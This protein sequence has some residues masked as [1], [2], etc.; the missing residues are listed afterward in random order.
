[1]WKYIIIL[2]Y[3]LLVFLWKFLQTG[4]LSTYLTLQF[5]SFGSL[6]ERFALVFQ[7]APISKIPLKRKNSPIKMSSETKLKKKKIK[8]N[9]KMQFYIVGCP[10]YFWNP[11]K[12]REEITLYPFFFKFIIKCIEWKLSVSFNPINVV[13]LIMYITYLITG[14]IPSARSYRCT[15]CDDFNM[16]INIISYYITI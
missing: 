13:I 11:I 12:K 4:R 7:F 2:D 3:Y 16:K 5:R 1:M 14:H 15:I 8:Q 10:F 6:Y 9:Q